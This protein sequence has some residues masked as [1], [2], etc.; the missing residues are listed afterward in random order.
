MLRAVRLEIEPD[1][2]PRMEGCALFA[3][4][5]TVHTVEDSVGDR[6]GHIEE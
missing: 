2:H 3:V 6:A 4:V 1:R 5:G